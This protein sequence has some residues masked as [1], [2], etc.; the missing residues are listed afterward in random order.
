MEHLAGAV[1]A[2]PATVLVGG[3]AGVGKS[4][5]VAEFLATHDVTALVGGCVAPPGLP[6]A[7]FVAALRGVDDA[8]LAPLRDGVPFADDARP[9]LFEGVLILLARLAERRP[10]V[11]VVEDAHWL[12]P[13]GRALLDFLVRNQRSVP[14][15]VFVVTYRSDER[16]EPVSLLAELA[17]LP[18]VRRFEV[19]RLSRDEV[20]AQVH[21]I[22]GE[23]PEPAFVREVFDRSGGNPLFVEALVDVGGPPPDRLLLGRVDRLPADAVAIVRAA[24]VAGN[25][26]SHD[27]LSRV[28]DVSAMRSTVDSG[29]LSVDGDGYA[30]RHA[31]IRDAVHRDLLPGER[32]DLHARYAAVL[33]ESAALAYHRLGAGDP[34]G[35]VTTAWRAARRARA[36]LAFAEQSALLD[37][38]LELWPHAAHLGVD[39]E[40]V[41]ESA[42]EAASRA[43]EHARGV[44]LTTEL[45]S[46]LDPR[47]EPVRVAAVLEQRARLRP[48][49]DAL[50]D[51]RAAVGLVSDDRIS[52]YLLNSLAVRLLEAG[53]RDEARDAALRAC[54]GDGPARAGALIT[55]AALDLRTGDPDDQAKRLRTARDIASGLAAHRIVL[56][57]THYESLLAAAHGSTAEAEAAARRGLRVAE[58]VGVARSSGAV[59]AIDLAD[60]LI[61]TG[62][63]DEALRVVAE[64]LDL[65]PPAARHAD[66]LCRRG[67]VL[68]HRGDPDRAERCLDRAR[69]LGGDDPVLAAHLH[70]AAGR[71]DVAADVVRAAT[72]VTWPLVAIAAEVGVGLPRPPAV[73]PVDRAWAAT[74]DRDPAAADVWTALGRPFET[75]RALL[76]VVRSDPRGQADALR[77]AVDLA[78]RLGAVDMRARLADLA[79]RARVV[80][81]GAGRARRS[82]LGLTPRETEILRLVADGL[83]NR[84]I[85][86]RLFISTK[87]ASV[88]VSNILGKLG[89]ANRVAAAAAAHRL[90]LFE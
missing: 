29:V 56:R 62:R 39:R 72:P 77:R 25:R 31:L 67:F 19:E 83:G 44:E 27:V 23:E 66:L 55:L 82:R 6:Y 18:H 24:S 41:L 34:A 88:H 68:L 61:A 90:R 36:A 75:L 3:E 43:G 14:G 8:A 7:P 1:H 51:H 10:V 74:V 59:H 26:V 28:V 87:T 89:V 5:L 50:D 12:D 48:L 20:R 52:S 11:L 58:E 65:V 81:D 42:G 70:R 63:W 16:A 79:R 21:A 33:P 22:L 85:A 35:A 15:S 47:T 73:C 69:A 86:A 78:D 40:S 37:L 46:R 17:R 54:A 49:P 4:R 2:A 30:F 57:A 9:R 64:A 13:A 80:L 84:E 32:A 76:D 60:V 45:L 38:V 53:L 71:D